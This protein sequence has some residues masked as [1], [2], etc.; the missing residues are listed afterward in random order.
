MSSEL[1]APHECFPCLQVV[2]LFAR[3]D[4]HFR[5]LKTLFRSAARHVQA[6]EREVEEVVEL[7]HRRVVRGQGAARRERGP[8]R[9][10]G[11]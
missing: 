2:F 7:V 10:R 8:S 3:P 6:L 11:S 9:G 1:R 5:Y 4:L